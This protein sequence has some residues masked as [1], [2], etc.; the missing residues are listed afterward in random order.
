MSAAAAGF[1]K[2]GNVVLGGGSGGG[3]G[4]FLAQQAGPI[5]Q[6]GPSGPMHTAFKGEGV[7]FASDGDG[8]MASEGWEQEGRQA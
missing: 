2:S 1:D 4:R 8:V 7:H 5:A 3:G 6:S